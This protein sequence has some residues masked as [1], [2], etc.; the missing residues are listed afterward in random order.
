[1]YGEPL[2]DE[3]VLT[4]AEAKVVRFALDG[5]SE[6]DVRSSSPISKDSERNTLVSMEERLLRV[7]EFA[8]TLGIHGT[9]VYVY[10]PEIAL[11]NYEERQTQANR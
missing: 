9:E 10:V 2:P 3:I 1:M 6:I 8:R 4:R 5:A 7:P 11:R